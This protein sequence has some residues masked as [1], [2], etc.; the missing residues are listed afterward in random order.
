MLG[1]TT[2]DAIAFGS[3]C[4]ALLAAFAGLVRGEHAKDAAPPEPGLTLIGSGLVDR[5]TLRDLTEAVEN[6]VAVLRD[7][8]VAGEARSRDHL[9]EQIRDLVDKI[10]HRTTR[11]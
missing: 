10:D 7:G 5:E 9:A 1:I 4:A 3:L 8:I 6:L 11:R 2:A